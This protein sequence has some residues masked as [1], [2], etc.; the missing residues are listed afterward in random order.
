[1]EAMVLNPNIEI[2]NNV[3]K[4][5]R[6]TIGFNGILRFF[7]FLVIC[8]IFSGLFR[9]DLSS[10]PYVNW[11][12]LLLGLLLCLQTDIAL[13]L[14]QRNPDPFVLMMTYLLT[15]FY[16]L[17]IYTLLL[18]PVQNVFERYSFGPI[19]SNNALLYIIV[20]NTC[21]YAGF[22]RVKLSF[23]SEEDT[24]D[25]LPKKPRLGIALFAL[26]LLFGLL[27]Q[28]HL[29]ENIA[30]YLNLVYN[31]LLTPNFIL[32]VL[33]TYVVTFRKHLPPIYIK[34]VLIGAT[35][36][37]VLQT[38]AFSRSGI[39][40]YVDNLLIVLL[41]LMPL[42]RL[43]LKYVVS[44][45]FLLPFF[46]V[47]AFTLFSIST[48]TLSVKGDRGATLTEKVELAQ[49]TRELVKDDPR[50]DFFLGQLLSRA[51]YFDYSA[52]IIANSKLYSKVFTAENYFKSITDNI[53]TPG[54][55]VFDMPMLSSALKYTY[56]N[57]GKPSRKKE[58]E[59]GHTDQF[60]LYG[61]L[62]A[63]FGYSSFLLLYFLAYKLKRVYRHGWPSKPFASALIRVLLMLGFYRLMNSFGLDW[64]I[65]D[66]L[67]T[68]LSFVILYRFFEFRFG[69]LQRRGASVLVENRI[70]N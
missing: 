55:D 32:L 46:M 35:V 41:A 37:L 38:L 47:I 16:S 52:E 17:R 3:E 25:F 57:L 67:I 62:Y 43:R 33:A 20:A 48:A 53:L 66:L 27:I 15:F 34:T 24:F 1:M 30:P 13:R 26:S 11:V 23:K 45:F 9:D 56:N 61:E 70:I 58:I 69:I 54:F 14:E 40:T 42:F 8:L 59:A 6:K 50:I 39:L 2:S 51:G 31:N 18:Y 60:G 5:S 22:Y 28:S 19:D 49:D 36:L 44:G 65:W 68:S 12:T 64:V 7:N 63:L 21:I 29:P 4:S 10:N